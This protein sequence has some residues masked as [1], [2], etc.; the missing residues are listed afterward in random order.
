MNMGKIECAVGILTFNSARTLKETLE[1]VKNFGEIIVCD[2]G[3]TDDTLALARAFGA[4]VIVQDSQYKSADNKIVDFSGVRN[5]MLAQAGLEWF[6]Y[7]DSDELMT[8]ELETEI[9]AII[10][11][12]HLAA[13]F[14]VPRKYVLNNKIVNCAAT[15]PTKQMRFFHRGVVTKFIKTIHERIEV[16]RGAPVLCLE[17]FMLVPMN[18]DPKFHRAKWRHYIELEVNRRGVISLTDWFLVCIENLKI[19]ILYFF[20]YVRNLFFCKGARLPWKLEWERHMYHINMCG[21]FWKLVGK[22]DKN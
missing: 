7:L 18:P 21:E 11:S 17:N 15:Y 13:A 22:R 5:Q 16:K 14:W 20:R 4:K 10:S 19:S 3:S 9:D 6:F 2:G 8:H 12:G 1:S